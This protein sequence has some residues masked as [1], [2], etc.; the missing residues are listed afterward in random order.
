MKRFY[1]NEYVVW[2]EFDEESTAFFEEKCR[3][4]DAHSIKPG[5]R[6]PHM[7]ISFAR[8]DSCFELME[9]TKSFFS[10]NTVVIDIDEVDMFTNR[11][12]FYKPRQSEDLLSLQKD[13]CFGLLNFAKLS[14]NLYFP[15]NWTPHIALTD[16]LSKRQ[17]IAAQNLMQKDFTPRSNVKI[18]KVIVKNCYTGEVFLSLDMDS[19]L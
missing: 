5:V 10:K 1:K 9:Y 2:V 12:V 18:K 6:P 8:T 17:S 16:S 3:L 4:L 7:T 19:L 11:V 13:F 15:K 14:W